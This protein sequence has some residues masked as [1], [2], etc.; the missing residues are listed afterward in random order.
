MLKQLRGARYCPPS[1]V[2]RAAIPDAGLVRSMLAQGGNV[3]TGD[4]YWS[5]GKRM[6]GC[7]QDWCRGNSQEVQAGHG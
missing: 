4:G 7:L 1:G 6:K 5:S 3:V 2:G